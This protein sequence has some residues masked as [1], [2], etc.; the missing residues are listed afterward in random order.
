[1]AV[2]ES[3]PAGGLSDPL[4]FAFGP[5]I[6][7]GGLV[8]GATL[9]PSATLAP[10]TIATIFGTQLAPEHAS[11]TVPYPTILGGV[12][13]SVDGIAAPLLFVSPGQ[14]NF[15]VPWEVATQSQA[16]VVVNANGLASN[17]VS[18]SVTS[19]APGIFTVNAAGQGAVLIAGTSSLAAPEGAFPGSRPVNRGES[20]E[21]FATGLGAVSNQPP[22]GQPPS[23]LATTLQNV[24]AAVGCTGANGAGMCDVTAFGGSIEFSGLASGFIGLYQVNIQ[25]PAGAMSGPAIALRLSIG[26][27]VSNTVTIAI[28]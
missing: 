2:Y 18:V 21:I 28:Q 19:T 16:N 10:G 7:A 1:V 17:S 4:S 25:L 27:Q 8:N 22:D 24:A 6:S 15:V 11:A 20:I 9:S 26:E 13:V 12:S 3:G 23:G 14:I 5:A